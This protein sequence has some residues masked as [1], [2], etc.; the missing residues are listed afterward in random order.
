MS[1]DDVVLRSLVDIREP[2][3]AYAVIWGELL[4]AFGLGLVVALLVAAALSLVL[5]E[6]KAA[7][8]DLDERLAALRNLPDGA[9]A[10]AL[11]RLAREMGYALP[12]ETRM[13]LYRPGGR[14]DADALEA[15]LAAR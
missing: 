4:L 2:G 5:R 11:A 3:M 8:P 10:L 9:R 7:G 14:V 13:A 15:A 1:D 12:D 6:R